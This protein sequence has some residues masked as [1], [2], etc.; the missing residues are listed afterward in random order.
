M[1][2][3][4]AEVLVQSVVRRHDTRFPRAIKF[5]PFTDDRLHYAGARQKFEQNSGGQDT[6]ENREAKSIVWRRRHFGDSARAASA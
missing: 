1:K 4:G 6:M 3:T 5:S 2:W